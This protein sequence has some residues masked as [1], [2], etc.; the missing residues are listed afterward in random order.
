MKTY[1]ISMHIS[2]EPLK[3]LVVDTDQPIIRYYDVENTNNLPPLE[4]NWRCKIDVEDDIE[5]I[6]G[7]LI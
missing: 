7:I 4:A 1:S 6:N 3:I 5:I 2:D